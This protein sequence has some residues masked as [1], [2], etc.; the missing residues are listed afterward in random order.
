MTL[1]NNNNKL[2][3]FKF[4]NVFKIRY[5]FNKNKYKTFMNSFLILDYYLTRIKVHSYLMH[6]L[7]L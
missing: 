7:H 5:F 3:D 2:K 6:L 4:K 1:D